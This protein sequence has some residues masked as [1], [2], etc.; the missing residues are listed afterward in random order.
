MTRSC[1][2]LGRKW[3][4]CGAYRELRFDETS[5]SILGVKIYVDFTYFHEFI[6]DVGTYTRVN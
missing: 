3:R 4:N 1:L 6:P 5:V 2:L